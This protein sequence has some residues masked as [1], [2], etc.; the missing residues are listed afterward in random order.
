MDYKVVVVPVHRLEIVADK[1]SLKA[2]DVPVMFGVGAY[3]ADG[4]ELDTLDGVQLAWFIGAKREIAK[5]HG[6]QLGPIIHLKPEGSGKGAVICAL[7]DEFYENMEP[8]T[9]DIKVS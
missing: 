1:T 4:N 9:L 6:S 7:S 5:F 8:A 3:D 2:E